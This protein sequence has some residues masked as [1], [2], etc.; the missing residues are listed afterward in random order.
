M[1]VEAKE[2]AVKSALKPAALR[3]GDR[4]ALVSPASRPESP[5][6]VE[7]GK[8]IVEEMGFVP[9]VGRNALRVYGYMAGTDAERL[10]DLVDA[11]TDDSIA[12]VFFLTGGYGSLHLLNGIDY[13]AVEKR[14]KIVVGCDDNTHLLLA[15]NRKTGLVTFHGPNLDQV[16]SRFTFDSLKEAITSKDPLTPMIPR[17]SS[18][19]FLAKAVYSPVPGTVS[20]RVIAGNLTA[21]VS[22]MGTPFEPAFQDS[23]LLLEDRDER[24]DILDRWFTTLYVSGGLARV[25]GVGFGAFEGCSTKDSNNMLSLEDLFGDRLSALNKPSCFGLNFGQA[26]DTCTV[27]IGVAATLEMSKGALSFKEPA[28]S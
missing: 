26:K 1:A 3:K 19:D 11:L 2:L 20:G 8:R 5:A 9:V 24:H 15:L 25:S 7:R 18:E 17:S 27:P 28:V 21:L 16:N 23:L 4:V 6:A 22:L 13:A 14:P 12:G 10:D